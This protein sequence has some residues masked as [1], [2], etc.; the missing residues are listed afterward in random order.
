MPSTR[1]STHMNDTSDHSVADSTNQTDYL[2]RVTYP[3]FAGMTGKG[4]KY[5]GKIALFPSNS[6]ARFVVNAVTGYKYDGIYA[7]SRGAD[8]F[9]C[10]VDSTSPTQYIKD[11]DGVVH[12]Q[13]PSDSNRFYYD[14]PE[15][16]IATSRKRGN[17]VRIPIEDINRWH[18]RKREEFGGIDS[19][20]ADGPAYDAFLGTAVTVIR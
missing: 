14:S 2:D 6:P 4:K 10:V 11:S 16:Y 12:R 19:G 20:E 18:D 17:I 15:E 1:H 13:N 3:K 9:F 7:L 5:R 8:R